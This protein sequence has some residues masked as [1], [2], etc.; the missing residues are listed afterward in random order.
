MFVLST[1][2]IV[3]LAITC[4]LGYL[5]Y[6]HTRTTQDYLIAGRK[7]HPAVMA[8]SYG[9]TFISTSAI[10]GFGGAAARLGGERFAPA[11]QRDRRRR[12]HRAARGERA[13]AR[14]QQ[15]GWR[16]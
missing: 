4:Y 6:R 13:P 10:V 9:A 2:V 14:M 12:Q 1:V 3:Y 11:Q 15:I 7:M 16:N 5:G 8:L